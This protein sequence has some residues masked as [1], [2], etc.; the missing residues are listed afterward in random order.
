MDIEREWWKEAVVYQVYPRSFNDTD[1]DGVGDLRGVIEKVD[2][3]D[4]LGV[5]VVWLNPVYESPDADNGYDIADYRSIK[6]QFGTMG[7]WE[8]LLDEL[9]SRDMRLI[10]DLVVNHTSD[11]HDWFVRSRDPESE[12]H[13]YYYWRD[14]DGED[15]PNNWRSFFSGS[16]WT[17]DEAV[18][19][20]YLHLF[21]EKQPDLNWRNEAVR[22]E[23]FEMM[24]WWL[25]KGIDGFRMD[26]INLISK[27]EGL[28][29]GDPDEGLP[30][31]EHYVSGPRFGE[32][33]AEMDERVLADRDIM[34]VG[35]M[36]DVDAA[37]GR[38][39]V[40]GDD[41]L[42][43]LIHFEHMGV[44]TGDGKW[45]VTGLDLLEL[46]EV[47][48]A[49]Q[50]ELHGEGWNCLYLSN[51]DQPRQVSRFGDDGEYR[52][53]SAKMLATFLHTLQGTPFVFQGE[54]IG[55]TNNEFGSVDEF[56]DVESTNFAE[57]AVERGEFD[58]ADEVLPLLNDRSRD[59]ART[60]VQWTDGERAG[61]TDGEPWIQVNDNHESVNVAAAREDPD[62]VWHH[63][64]DLIDLRTE[65]DVVVYGDYDLLLPDHEEVYAFT[66]TLGDERLLTVCN[67]FDGEPTFEL[68]DEVEYDDADL[69]LAN[70]DDAGDDPAAFT[71]RP[72]EARVYDLH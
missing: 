71:L 64:R 12:Y 27:A 5:D 69:L 49:W 38:E 17:Y 4:D 23:V 44:D 6:A 68:P 56:R 16:A 34:T 8:E 55:M 18:G 31:A 41:G 14:G 67:F 37:E 29:S 72:Y 9:H 50:N 48:S 63:Y 10:M 43:M 47:I 25:E 21:D 33:M 52:V 59:H 19:Q 51:H 7:D 61:F 15:P 58:E 28:P 1:G 11:E 45:D 2:Y 30:R 54:E 22:D 65:R 53:E 20:Y 32:Y 13:D 57:H 36:I 40:A 62:S 60:P 35:E 42:D 26:V 3:L 70:Y 39:Y 24:N 66:R 46:K